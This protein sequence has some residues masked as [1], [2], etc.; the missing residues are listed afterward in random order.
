MIK[1]PNPFAK[2]AAYPTTIYESDLLD[3]TTDLTPDV[4]NHDGW[5]LQLADG[6]GSSAGNF[7]GEKVLSESVTFDGTVLFTTFVPVQTNSAVDCAP[8]QGTGAV[9]AVNIEDARPVQDLDATT[10]SNS[11]TRSDRRVELTRTGIAP[12]VTILFPPLENVRP[13]AIVAAEK[14]DNIQLDTA[15][16]KTYWFMNQDR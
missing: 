12:E 11:L 15:P 5:Y 1:D 9:Y 13:Q 8:N 10:A 16:S 4:S 3:T 2:P 7:V 6:T 14:L